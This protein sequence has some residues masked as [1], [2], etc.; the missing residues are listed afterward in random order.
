MKFHDNSRL[1]DMRKCPRRYYW[2]H[3]RH[4]TGTGIYPPFI[5]G[6]AWHSAL[7]TLWPLLSRDKQLR[8]DEAIGPAFAAFCKTWAEEGGAPY[9]DSW[10]L[11]QEE[12]YMPRTPGIA[13]EMLKGYCDI[14]AELIGKCRV[15]SVEQ[16]FIL[17]LP[18][19]KPDLYC[20]KIDKIVEYQKQKWIVEHKTSTQ[21]R[22]I[23]GI[24]AEAIEDVVHGPQVAGQLHYGIGM[25]DSDFG[26]VMCDFSLV[27][28]HHHDIHMLY[29]VDAGTAALK[30]WEFDVSSLVQDIREQDLRLNDIVNT[31]KDMLD[32]SVMRAYPRRQSQCHEKY[33]VCPYYE[34][35]MDYPNPELMLEPP[36]GKEV[37]RWSPFE[38][39]HLEKLGLTDED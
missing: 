32:P 5:Y 15:I 13:Y 10:G 30:Q 6:S 35:C 25:W 34:T 9:D 3:R 24:A 17:E 1:D 27:H 23:G 7:D 21:F 33:G 4:F 39:L 37:K 22:K 16:P 2:R 20:G 29:P 19:V 38:H 12:K 31:E 8:A 26:G 18:G 28:K 11:E 36:E 14:R